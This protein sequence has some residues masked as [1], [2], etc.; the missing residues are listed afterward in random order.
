MRNLREK[1]YKDMKESFESSPMN[2]YVY[3]GYVTESEAPVM[4]D[5]MLGFRAVEIEK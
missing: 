5:G 4:L 3:T 2:G 1:S